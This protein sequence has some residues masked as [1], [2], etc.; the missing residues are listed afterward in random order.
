[1]DVVS[2][3]QPRIDE[4]PGYRQ[5]VDDLPADVVDL[6]AVL[7]DVPPDEVYLDSFHTNER[8]A[9]LVAEAMWSALANRLD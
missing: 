3:W 2:F 1:V 4:P 7:D 8:G 5:L 6:T 9:R